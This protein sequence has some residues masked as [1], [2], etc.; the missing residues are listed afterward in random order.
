VRVQVKG[1][2]GEVLVAADPYSSQVSRTKKVLTAGALPF[3]IEEQ[4]EVLAGLLKLYLIELPHPLIPVSQF[5]DITDVVKHKFKGNKDKDDGLASIKKVLGSIPAV[6]NAMCRRLLSLLRS[7]VPRHASLPPQEYSDAS[8][9]S[10]SVLGSWWSNEETNKSLIELFAPFFIRSEAKYFVPSDKELGAAVHAL[11]IMLTYQDQLF[12]DINSGAR[13]RMSLVQRG[14]RMSM[15]TLSFAGPSLSVP[16]GLSPIKEN[17]AGATLS[18]PVRSLVSSP[19][20]L[21]HRV[22]AHGI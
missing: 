4:P 5:K 10:C 9:P 19:L 2:D 1:I 3:A 12:A 6:N 15:R 7:Y 20:L 22:D 14:E 17:N 13:R 21:F 18:P 8:F 16:T 11:G